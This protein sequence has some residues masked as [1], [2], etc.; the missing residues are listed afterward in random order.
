MKKSM[1]FVLVVVIFS[2]SACSSNKVSKA[3]LEKT[4]V[5]PV[6]DCHGFIAPWKKP[7]YCPAEAHATGSSGAFLSKQGM[8]QIEMPNQTLLVI[9]SDALFA[10]NS[11]ELKEE[12]YPLL[13]ALTSYLKQYSD[14]KIQVSAHVDP[15]GAFKHRETLTTQQATAVTGYLWAHGVEVS[16][17]SDRVT[18]LGEG[19]TKPIATNRKIRGMALNRRIEISMRDMPQEQEVDT[20]RLAASLKNRK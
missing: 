15:I 8:Q 13:S 10:P 19:A 11:S 6:E 20:A 12:A 17:V 1:V 7:Y 9:P 16:P 4:N 5:I 3:C 18:F 14:Q 2:L